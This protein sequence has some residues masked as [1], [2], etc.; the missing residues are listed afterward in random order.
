MD[1]VIELKHQMGDRYLPIAGNHDV[2]VSLVVDSNSFNARERIG[3][4]W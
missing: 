3:K 1:R 4:S 2:V